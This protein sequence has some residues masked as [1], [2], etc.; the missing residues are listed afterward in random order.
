MLDW[1][2]PNGSQ[3]SRKQGEATETRCI[4][5]SLARKILLALPRKPP[6]PGFRTSYAAGRGEV[7][8]T[9]FADSRS[10]E[11]GWT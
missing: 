6:P 2:S 11:R 8:I 9:G 5:A 3:A 10:P 1:M 7:Q 4:A